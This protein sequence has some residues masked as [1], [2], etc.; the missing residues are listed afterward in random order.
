MTA[1]GSYFAGAFKASNL[2]QSWQLLN[3][4]DH[5][6]TSYLMIW[7]VQ[8]Q[9]QHN[10]TDPGI[11]RSTQTAFYCWIWQFIVPTLSQ[12]LRSFPTKSRATLFFLCKQ[13]YPFPPPMNRGGF[14]GLNMKESGLKIAKNQLTPP[15]FFQPMFLSPR[16]FFSTWKPHRNLSPPPT[17]D[18]SASLRT[19]ILTSGRTAIANSFLSPLQTFFFF[20]LQ[21]T[22]AT[23]PSV[24]ASW[25]TSQTYSTSKPPP[26]KVAFFFFPVLSPSSR[27]HCMQKIFCMQWQNN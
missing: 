3:Q 20:L 4:N 12:W 5:L 26:C 17:D 7:T 21:P 2:H 15:V 19:Q 11:N 8:A 1:Q 23:I 18:D 6:T 24:D 13:D 25:A 22:T 27:G 14:H 16:Y 10:L 9:R